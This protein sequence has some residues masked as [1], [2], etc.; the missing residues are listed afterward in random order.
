MNT[1]RLEY[2]L[3]I[4]ETGNLRQASEILH[5]TPPA[6][7]KAMKQ[8]EEEMGLKLWAPD[9]RRIILTDSGKALLKRAPALINE[10]KSLR[11]DLVRAKDK[12]KPI[13]IGTF[14]TFSTYFLTFL[15]T[16][17]WQ[18]RQLELHELLPGEVEKYLLDGAIDVGITY[19]PIPN[20]QLDFIKVTSI[21]MGVYVKKGA[22]KGVAQDQL[23]YVVP[24]MPLQGVPTKVRGLDGW[25]ED[26]SF[27]RKVTH[28]VTL[29]ESALELCR[30]GLVAGYFPAFVACEHNKRVTEEFQLE[31]RRAP[32]LT[33][34]KIRHSDVFLVKR[35]S[36]EEDEII[37]QLAKAIRV[38]C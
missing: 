13:R 8:L 17:S 36:T 14:E 27:E 30:Q 22:F 31:R 3:T 1:R 2:F 19:L 6:L 29:M 24:V 28:R 25:P 15:K 38:I 26:D 23:P 20:A 10:F 11:E 12:A 34:C 16:L 33:K 18:D 21:E 5:L 32:S 4:A 9:G 37:R 35:K 7:S